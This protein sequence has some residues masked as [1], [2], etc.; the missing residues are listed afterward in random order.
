MQ[1]ILAITLLLVIVQAI[2][3][4]TF[5]IKVLNTPSITIDGKELK[6]GNHFD[7][8]AK[9]SW[10]SDS[11]A[12]KV[13]SDDNHIY[14]ISPKIFAKYHVKTFIDYLTSVKSVTV[15]TGWTDFPT[16]TD[17]HRAIFEGC[18]VLLD[19][20]SFNV[21][22]TVDDNS[23]FEATTN[24]LGAEK[25]SFKIPYNGKELFITKEL[26][27][28]LPDSISSISLTVKYIESEFGES[29]V[30]TDSL[31]IELVPDFLR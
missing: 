18:F 5:E 7:E 14:V 13:L 26:F 8:N 21:G 24:D 30:I 10:R 28:S 31:D 17:D 27:D 29:T 6:V 22:W 25:L 4:K 1:R 12:M 15:R 19:S 16:T 2:S 23:Y 20:L 3:G 11:Q 9:I